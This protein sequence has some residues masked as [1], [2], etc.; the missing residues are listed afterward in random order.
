MQRERFLFVFDWFV[1]LVLVF[2][3]IATGIGA[4]RIHGSDAPPPS[5][6]YWKARVSTSIAIHQAEA[7]PITPIPLDVPRPTRTTDTRPVMTAYSVRWCDVEGKP[8][9]TAKDALKEKADSLPY[10]VNWVDVTDGGAPP[11]CDSFPSFEWETDRRVLYV[12]G[13]LGVEQLTRTWRAN[14]RSPPR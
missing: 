8:C 2:M 3:L 12:K 6:D 5:A 11:W 14:Q 4:S 10:R 1:V 7:N 13:W 9:R